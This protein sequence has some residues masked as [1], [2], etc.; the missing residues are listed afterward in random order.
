MYQVICA[1]TTNNTPQTV[2]NVE[3]FAEAK[4]VLTKWVKDSE[5]SAWFNNDHLYM[6]KVSE[7]YYKIIDVRKTIML[8]YIKK[9]A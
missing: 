5:N 6:H 9:V 2:K 7:V 4:S 3:T 8:L 1:A